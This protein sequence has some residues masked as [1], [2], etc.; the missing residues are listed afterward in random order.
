[1]IIEFVEALPADAGDN[2]ARPGRDAYIDFFRALRV[3][4][5]KWAVFPRQKS[6]DS[7][8]KAAHHIRKGFYHG[9]AA[10]EF[11]AVNRNGTLYV[12]FAEVA[13]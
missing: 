10:G 8:R 13:S 6:S 3:K 11:E 1:M 7:R 5:G 2:G 9:A 12:R 4:P